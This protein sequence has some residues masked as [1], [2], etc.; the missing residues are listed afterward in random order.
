MRVQKRD[1]ERHVDRSGCDDPYGGTIMDSVYK[2]H[3]MNGSVS[4]EKR[5]P[6]PI[7]RGGNSIGSSVGSKQQHRP[8]KDDGGAH[9][10]GEKRQSHTTQSSK[11]EPCA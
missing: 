3:Q 6:D 2:V 8:Y 10:A 11:R 5:S 7:F 4:V 9:E 1:R